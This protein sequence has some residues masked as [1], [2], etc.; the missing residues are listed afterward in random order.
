MKSIEKSTWYHVQNDKI[1]HYFNRETTTSI[2]GLIN[3]K[4]FLFMLDVPRYSKAFLQ[5]I[6]CSKCVLLHE[7]NIEANRLSSHVGTYY[8]KTSCPDCDADCV[9][10]SSKPKLQDKTHVHVGCPAND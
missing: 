8:T 4:K 9:I 6:L 3:S 2:C 1:N 7:K 10:I 5:K